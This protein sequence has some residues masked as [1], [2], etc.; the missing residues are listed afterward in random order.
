VAAFSGFL[1]I[2]AI[3]PVLPAHMQA[4]LGSGDVEIGFVI[5]ACSIAALGSRIAS[6]RLVDAR[7]GILGVKLGLVLSSLAGLFAMLPVGLPGLVAARMAQGVGAA[8]VFS[9]AAA[10]IV[11]L[12]P[13]NQRARA[14]GLLAVGPWGALAVGPPAGGLIGSFLGVGDRHAAMRA[15]GA[16]I[17]DIAAGKADL[18][19]SPGAAGAADR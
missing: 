1:G 12:D 10:K 5:G 18:V 19:A 4:D 8:F 14:M 11:A 9:G 3:V 7:G 13:V 6:G 17:G 16:P 15:A 2:G